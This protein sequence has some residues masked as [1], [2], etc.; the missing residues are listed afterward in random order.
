[1][2]GTGGNVGVDNV[3]LPQVEGPEVEIRDGATLTD[4]L[5]LQANNLTVR[6]LAILGFGVTDADGGIRVADNFTDWLIEDNVLGT[7]ATSFTDPGTALRNIISVNVAGGD[8]GTIQNNLIGFAEVRGVW[9]QLGSLSSTVSG[10]EIDDNGPESTGG[11]GI[12][13]ASASN[14]NTI[15]GNL[16]TGTSSQGFVV[17]GSSA[18]TFLNNTLTGNGVGSPRRSHNPP[19]ITIR[20]DAQRRGHYQEH[21][22]RKLRG[23]HTGQP[24]CDAHHNISKLFC[25]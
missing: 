6:G 7:T 22:S 20:N 13:I 17:T 19:R 14:N 5:V 10:N 8:S 12:A 1:M 11:D 25:R 21:R 4:G 3:A 24:Q 18:I 15:S 9:L 23:R 2:L 16:I